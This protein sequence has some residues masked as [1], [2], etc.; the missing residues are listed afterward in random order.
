[1]NLDDLWLQ[2]ARRF[3]AW[4]DDN[5]LG[6]ESEPEAAYINMLNRI[7]EG[8]GLNIDWEKFVTS[9]EQAFLA[10]MSGFIRHVNPDGSLRR[11]YHPS[12]ES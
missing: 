4:R 3:R 2:A 11:N 12:C 1:M 6:A 10:D 7:H 8:S 9:P 5:D